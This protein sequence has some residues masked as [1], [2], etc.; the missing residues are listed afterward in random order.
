MKSHC[1]ASIVTHSWGSWGSEQF[2]LYVSSGSDW[3][4]YLNYV[5][6]K[7]EE[8]EERGKEGGRRAGEGGAG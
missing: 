8:E 4:I 3:A 7:K 6:K 2:G 5:S 1:E